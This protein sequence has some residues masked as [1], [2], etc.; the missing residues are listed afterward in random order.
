MYV[1]GN[2]YS[3]PFMIG[4][5]SLIGIVVNMAIF[6]VDRMNENINRGL[7]IEQAIIEAAT[8]RFKPVIISSITTIGGII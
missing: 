1:T 5:I 3:M 8:T 2:P 4:F 6:L 7:S